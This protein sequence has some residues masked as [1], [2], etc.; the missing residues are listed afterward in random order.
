M[1]QRD[2]AE[3]RCAI[4]GDSTIGGEEFSTPQDDRLPA[5]LEED[6]PFDFLAMPS[7][8]FI[9]HPSATEIG[10][11]ERDKADALLHGHERT[12]LDLPRT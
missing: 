6:G 9:E 11:T 10:D 12:P 8:L 4:V 5:G 1:R 3:P 2:P 7:E